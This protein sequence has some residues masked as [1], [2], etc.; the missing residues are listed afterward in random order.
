MST[1]VGYGFSETKSKSEASEIVTEYTIPPKSKTTVSI[2]NSKQDLKQNTTYKGEL[3]FGIEIYS[4]KRFK[5]NFDSIEELES[6]YR[7]YAIEQ[8]A[9]NIGT[10]D[11]NKYARVV[12]EM[13]KDYR[14]RVDTICRTAPITITKPQYFNSASTGKIT[15]KSTKL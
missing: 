12:Y 9:G 2:L 15:I 3:D 5:F 11:T 13:S 6:F 4:H 7:G 8:Q 14:D 1:S 10:T